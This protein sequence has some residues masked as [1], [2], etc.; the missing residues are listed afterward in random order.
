MGIQMNDVRVYSFC[1]S[2]DKL[3]LLKGEVFVHTETEVERHSIWS[4]DPIT[5]GE[6]M[7]LEER[8]A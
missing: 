3:V 6:K 2:S 5:Q 8:A 1:D 4:G 7:T